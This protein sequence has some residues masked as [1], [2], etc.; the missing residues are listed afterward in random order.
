LNN[1][2]NRIASFWFYIS[3]HGEVASDSRATELATR[4]VGFKRWQFTADESKGLSKGQGRL[5]ARIHA[6]NGGCYQAVPCFQG[7]RL[8]IN[9]LFEILIISCLIEC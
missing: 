8:G 1:L 9:V 4:R 5:P 6:A 2:N 7:G 3:P